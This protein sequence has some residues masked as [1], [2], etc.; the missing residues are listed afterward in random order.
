MRVLLI[1]AN[2]TE[3]NMRTIPLGIACVASALNEVGHTV[4]IPDCM[5]IKD[6]FSALKAVIEE[7]RLEVIGISLRNIDDQTIHNPR[8]LLDEDNRVI[9]LAKSFSDAPVIEGR[10]MCKRSPGKVVEWIIRLHKAPYSSKAGEP[11]I[12]AIFSA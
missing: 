8:L 3:I 10:I 6:P 2:R 9:E 5:E 7:F 1:S 12:H 11:G 4:Q